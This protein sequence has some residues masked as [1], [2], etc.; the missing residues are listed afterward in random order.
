MTSDQIKFLQCLKHAETGDRN[1]QF[2]LGCMYEAGI[3]VTKNAEEAARWFRLSA[4]QG[5]A[6][7]IGRNSSVHSGATKY[8]QDNNNQIKYSLITFIFLV[9]GY[10]IQFY[11]IFFTTLGSAKYPTG[12]DVE[13]AGLWQAGE[14]DGLIFLILIAFGFV[15]IIKNWK[16]MSW[17]IHGILT[18]AYFWGLLAVVE[19][20]GRYENSVDA[21]IG[22]AYP[23]LVLGNLIVIITWLLKIKNKINV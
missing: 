18:I 13:M 17:L 4:A 21:E 5:N 22:L 19:L 6:Q 11:A 10:L 9:L 8:Q 15:A 20:V 23:L 12:D 14:G 7:A 16:F 1:A 3:G 2:D